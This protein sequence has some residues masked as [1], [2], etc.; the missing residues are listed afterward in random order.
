MTAQSPTALAAATFNEST[1]CAIGMRT[2][3]VGGRDRR[4]REALSLGAHHERHAVRDVRDER[5]EVHGAVRQG[6]RGEVEALR[7]EFLAGGRPVADAGPRHLQHRAHADADAAPVERVGAA[8]AD[9]DGVGPEA[10]DAPEHGADVGVVDDVLEHHHDLGVAHHVRD[11]R[12]LRAVHRGDGAAVH[13]EAGEV[14]EQVVGADEH[15]A[16]VVRDDRE[17]A[18]EPLLLDQHAPRDVPGADRPLDDRVRLGD[19]QAALR[20]GHAP[21]GDVGEPGEVVEAGVVEGVDADGV[22]GARFGVGVG[23]GGGGARPGVVHGK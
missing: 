3:G 10:G 16:V 5:V 11:A 13:P 22:H 8:G 14:L 7:P 18:V 9:Q 23:A 12:Q 17:H 15:G 4:R 19:V 21:Q 2:V 1:P 20:L 6:H